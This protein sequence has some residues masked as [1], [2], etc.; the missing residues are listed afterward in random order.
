MAQRRRRKKIGEILLAQGLITQDVLDQAMEEH[1]RSG[2]S[3]GTVLV[4][5]GHITQE[6]LESVLGLQLEL[7]GQRKRLG[8]ILV[9]QGFMTEAQIQECLEEQKRSGKQIGKLFIEKGY[10]DEQKLLD[11]ISA[12]IDV[13]RVILE[14]LTLDPAIVKLVPQEM[15]RSYK[16]IPIYERD[17]VLTVAMAD[18]SNLRTLDHIKFKTGRDVEPMLPPRRKWS[19]RSIACTCRQGPTCR[20]C[21]RDSPATTRSSSW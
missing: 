19:R 9:D 10:I 5:T 18:P 21:S 11:V 15:A 13:Q 6:T 20:R 7:T 16:V 4:Q 12:Q 17:N 1:K 2:T 3:L 14:N 8:E